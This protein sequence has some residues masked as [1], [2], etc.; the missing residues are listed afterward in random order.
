LGIVL[1]PRYSLIGVALATLITQ[2]LTGF[3]IVF[4]F[5]LLSK[6]SPKEL[7]YFTK[8][9]LLLYKNLLDRIQK[10]IVELKRK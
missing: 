10:K 5:W 2:I 6:K 9:D 7:F 8:E 1:I 3:T 4:I